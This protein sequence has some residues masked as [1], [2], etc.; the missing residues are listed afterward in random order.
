MQDYIL[1]LPPYDQQSAGIR[2]MHTLANELNRVGRNAYALFYRF[3]SNGQVELV[4]PGET[5]IGYCP[6][7]TLIKKLPIARDLE[8]YRDL[9]NRAIVIYPEVMQLNPLGAPNVVRYILNKPS[10]NG[11]EMLHLPEDYIVS[12]SSN[13]W[14]KSDDLLTILFDD[15][16]FHDRDTLP[17][18]LRRMDLTY[19]GK[20]GDFGDTFKIPGTVMLERR[21]PSDKESLAVL[22]RNSRY[23]L[24]W[25]LV[26]QTNL[27]ALRCGTIPVVLRWHPFDTS[28]FNTEFGEIPYAELQMQDGNANVVYDQ[29]IFNAK[30]ETLLSHYR[31]VANSLSERVKTFADRAERYFLNPPGQR[32]HT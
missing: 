25:D 29:A 27:D 10:N 32:R 22:L 18:E 20:G 8:E 17:A 26:S 5:M 21:W 11:Y 2:V 15:P 13:Y 19:V 23:L 1:L 9:I 12:W 24:T 6:E 4:S 30:R 31:Q 28:V 16:I 3:L 14:D 7:H